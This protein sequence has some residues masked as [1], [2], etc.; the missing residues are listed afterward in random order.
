MPM[1]SRFERDVQKV[2]NDKL[3]LDPDGIEAQLV[4]LEAQ[5]AG[6]ANLNHTH[7]I[8]QVNGLSSALNDK[9]SVASVNA[10]N[11]RLNA[12]TEDVDA[13]STAV[14]GLTNNVNNLTNDVAN[15]SSNVNNKADIVSGALQL[16][17]ALSTNMPAILPAGRMVYVSDAEKIAVSTGV[18]WLFVAMGAAV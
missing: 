8:A 5:V 11:S 7:S 16:P 9:A 18:S 3:N 14:N 15:L 2:V 13:L 4:A 10:L 17:A 1:P 12:T 6:K